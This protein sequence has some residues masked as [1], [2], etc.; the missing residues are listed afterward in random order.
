VDSSVDSV[1]RLLSRHR[2]CNDV[3][4]T[5]PKIALGVWVLLHG[6]S[7]VVKVESIDVP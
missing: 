1:N 2:Q 6:L 3:L 4:S 7:C 5:E